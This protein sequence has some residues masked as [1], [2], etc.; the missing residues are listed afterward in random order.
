MTAVAMAEATRRATNDIYKVSNHLSSQ[1]M[2]LFWKGFWV[3]YRG[4]NDAYHCTVSPYLSDPNQ[5]RKECYS[6]A[7]C[8][9]G[10][11][12]KQDLGKTLHSVHPVLQFIWPIQICEF[13]ATFEFILD[14]GCRIEIEE[15]SLIGA[16]SNILRGC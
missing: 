11:E 4:K 7:N 5:G 3:T 16:E 10:V 6:G 2:N 9:N 1:V 12:E 8:C 15:R 14:C 13:D